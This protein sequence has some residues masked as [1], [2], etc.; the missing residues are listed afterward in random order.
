MEVYRLVASTGVAPTVD[1]VARLMAAPA[2]RVRDAYQR[3]YKK[4]SLVI[5]E[6][7]ETIIMAPPFSGVETQHRVLIGETTYFANCS[8]DALGVLAALQREG[9]VFSRCEQSLAPLHLKVARDGPDSASCVVHFAVPASQWW[10][11]IVYT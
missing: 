2:D 8:W 1:R 5:A 11:D 9:E 3:L 10:D 4:R 6:D 7:G